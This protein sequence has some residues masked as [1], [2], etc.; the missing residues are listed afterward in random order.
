MRLVTYQLDDAWRPGVLVGETIVDAERAAQLAGLATGHGEMLSSAF[1]GN[2][3]LIQHTLPALRQLASAAQTLAAEGTGIALHQTRLGP[4]IP[5]PEKLILIGLNYRDHAHEA[6]QPLPKVPMVLPVYRNALAG[7][8]DA[9]VLPKG[10]RE[11]VDYEGELA[12][13]IG[14]QCKDVPE[15]DALACVAG[16]MVM[17]DVSARDMQ[18]Q[19]PQW[20]AAKMIDGF[21]PCGPALVLCD[22][23]ADLENLTVMTRVN[24]QEVQHS[25]T[26]QFIFSVRALVAY[27]SELVTLEAGDIIATGTPPGVGFSRKPPLFLR[28]GDRVEV[29]I[30]GIGMISNYV[31][32]P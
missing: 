9:I 30:P 31:I 2:R 24:G 20:A 17:N 4:P 23:I 1:V 10:H 14:R 29:E 26:S 22:E 27:L 5:D 3:Q 25:N 8:H 18:Q 32:A 11:Y 15:E 28:H 21:K 6:N 12:I 19:S 13:V 7:P 16:A